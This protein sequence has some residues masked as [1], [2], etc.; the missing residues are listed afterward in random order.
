M[1]AVRHGLVAAARTVLVAPLMAATIVTGCA[2]VGI[3]RAHLD[4]VFVEMVA[5]LDAAGESMHNAGD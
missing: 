4:H 5:A 2:G 3:G 1:V